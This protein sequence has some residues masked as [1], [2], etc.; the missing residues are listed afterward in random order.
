MAKLQTYADDPDVSAAVQ[1][2]T[3]LNLQ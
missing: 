2:M 3:E 1:K